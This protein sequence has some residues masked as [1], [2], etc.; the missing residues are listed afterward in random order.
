MPKPNEQTKR[1]QQ[2]MP[3]L[4]RHAVSLAMVFVLG[5]VLSY[6]AG[7]FINQRIQLGKLNDKD[8]ATFNEGLAYVV[9]H[10]GD[11][12]TVTSDALYKVS[13]LPDTTRAA[14][15]LLAIAKS[16][17]IREEPADP[18]I[19]AN[20]A[21]AVAPL[22]KRL[23]PMQAIG[24]YDGLV[25]INGINPIDAANNLLKSLSPKD[26]A[27]LL[28]IVDLLDTRLL[29]SRQW[30]P[31][32]L[33]VHWLN[34]LAKSEAELTQFNTAKR[35]GEL[36]DA[37]DEAR[38]VKALAT[39]ASSEYDTVRASVLNACAGYAAIATDPTD[40]EQIIFGLGKDPNKI[41]A[42]RAWMIVGHLNPFSGF[43]V[44]W[45]D[46]E[47]F[48][49]EAMLWAAVK[50]NPEN[51]KPAVSAIINRDL[52]REALLALEHASDM[53]LERLQEEFRTGDIVGQASSEQPDFVASWRAVLA[54]DPFGGDQ[55]YWYVYLDG[56]TRGVTTPFWT[57]EQK[58]EQSKTFLSR[59][60]AVT[61]RF[62][63]YYSPEARE[64]TPLEIAVAELAAVEGWILDK[65]SPNPFRSP[66]APFAQLVATTAGL[67]S[68]ALLELPST[69]DLARIPN[70]NLATLALTHDDGDTID[71]WLRSGSIP[72]RT[73]AA[74]AAAMIDRRTQMVTGMT[75]K[76]LL[77]NPDLTNDKIQAMTGD[78]LGK[79]GL[80]RIDALPALQE[81]AEAAPPSAN[82][83]VEAKLLK[84]ALWM[85]GD[86]GDDFTP[87][88]EAML[89][90]KELP[91]STVLMCL[92]HMQRPVAL[93]YLFGDLVTPRPDLYKL[94]IQ[95]RY[96]H[97]FRRFVD[98]A[99]L[100]LWLW[101]DPE[102]QAFQL[103]AMQQWYAV[104]R[105]KIEG[106]WWPEVIA[107]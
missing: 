93:D 107:K 20:V 80:S 66:S 46:A 10:A 40:Y 91:T 11:S 85:R 52:H 71:L 62:N 15:L 35:I 81:A 41:I 30:A 106:G 24:L 104:N 50:T 82:R 36:P 49:A 67:D 44:D 84:L 47:P 102:A 32:D 94:F 59:F 72:L 7:Q 64:L 6:F 79:M 97:V 26:D 27:E 63:E 100:T 34:V 16:H 95:E 13:D 57:A 77:N 74:L 90:D 31:L 1:A 65:Q 48:V 54:I 5:L 78:E 23:E 18:I 70:A 83:T 33:W 42:R 92:L 2:Q 53:Y 45:Q 37:V 88:A 28:Q 14:D 75:P 89:F 9:Q 60:L 8:Q 87:I 22:I 3:I 61:F 55:E 38:V 25:Q 96:W 43:A 29:W 73:P 56:V 4:A 103:E 101:G 98:T 69:I 21:D 39:L 86:L 58:T 68:I 12:E 51:P 99:D 17:A 105:W 76:L 19:P